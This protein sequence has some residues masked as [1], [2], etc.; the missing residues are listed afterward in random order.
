L[1]GNFTEIVA[2]LSP[3][4]I[5][6]VEQPVVV[7]I[8]PSRF[9]ER[10][11]ALYLESF[12]TRQMNHQFHYESEKQAGQWLAV[13]EAYS[14]AR[15]DDDCLR[16]YE[17]AFVEAA[18]NFRGDEVAL[19]SI[20]CGGGQKDLALLKVLK[21]ARLHYVPADVSV[22]LALTA[23]LRATAACKGLIS[24][25]LVL[26]LP[27]ANDLA[28]H[29]DSIV[30]KSAQ[31]VIAFF[32]MLPNF[33]PAEALN[34]LSTSLRPGDG[35]LISANLA[36][37]EDYAAGVQKILPLYD[38]EQTRRW[39]ATT[40]LDAGLDVSPHEIDFSIE[41]AHGLLRV[42]ANYRFRKVQTTR[43]DREEISYAPGDEF[44]LFFS[45]RHTPERLRTLLRQFEIDISQ[46]W[47]TGSGEEGVFLCHRI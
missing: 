31:R 34:P 7:T 26:D 19:I 10:T 28:Q 30:P 46:Q 1:L 2:R 37:G 11:R 29:L 33:E 47:I 18:K 45:Y 24:K 36:A 25:P 3:A 44:R 4:Y 21:A 43:I 40:L 41:P 20:G 9:P 23:H 8:H 12:R 27:H 16:T 13:H 14:P 42:E 15:T 38:N 22:P 39:L 32:G 5:T 35:L 17:R 6:E